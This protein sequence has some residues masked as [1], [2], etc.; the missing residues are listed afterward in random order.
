[1][2]WLFVTSEFPWPTNHGTWLRVYHLAK[3]LRRAGDAVTIFS[4]SGDAEGLSRYADI[5]VDVIAGGAGRG[6]RKG[7]S[8]TWFGP[9]VYDEAFGRSLGAMAAGFDVVLMFRETMLQYAP[10]ASLARCVIV[11]VVD[12][13][14]LARESAAGGT[15]LLGWTKRARFTAGLGGYERRFLKSVNHVNFVGERDR[16]CFLRR[17][18]QIS[19]TVIPNGVDA[20]FFQKPP[21]SGERL[22]DPCVTFTGNFIHRP[23]AE[24]AEFMIRQIA[25]LVWCQVP[26]VRFVLVGSNPPETVMKLAGPRVEVTGH[27]SDIRPWLWETSVALVP[28]VSGTGIKNKLLEAWGAEAP[29]V[30]TE[31]ACRGVPARDGD[32]L[33][34]G[35]TPVQLA[36]HIVRIIRSPELRKSLSRNGRRT[37]E[38]GATWAQSAAQF[39]TLAAG[40]VSPSVPMDGM[41]T[42]VI[43]DYYRNDTVAQNYDRDRFASLSGKIFDALEKH[44]FRKMMNRVLE[45]L[46]TPSVIDV[47]CG[48]G[49]ITEVLLGLGVYVTGADISEEMMGVAGAKCSRFGDRVRFQRLDL[50]S[51]DLPE[52]A[53]DVVTCI[54]MLHHLDARAR[55]NV[56]RSLARISRKYVL[57]NLSFSSPFYRMRRRLKRLVGLGISRESTTWKQLLAEAQAAG[58]V[59]DSCR[60]VGPGISEDLIVLLR[61]KE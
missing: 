5:G 37:V 40:T 7:P 25:P 51:P 53:Y 22:G 55:E 34:V 56:L 19:T 39:R 31:L 44:A 18:R 20:E 2:K 9:Y 3:E 47:P 30:A 23:N 1:M 42:E 33:L 36:E 57:I 16:Q 27:V 15:G 8:R 10:E 21:T 59:V 54:R 49:R 6:P 52:K 61:L 45:T 43:K 17:N 26:T 13:P 29:V 32:N 60:F 11:D 35:R 4:Y 48:T 24:A 28:M 12:D 50:D 58:L 46:P 14:I 38:E 41:A